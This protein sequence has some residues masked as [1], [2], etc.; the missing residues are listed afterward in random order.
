MVTEFK[1]SPRTLFEGIIYY[2][3]EMNNKPVAA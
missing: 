3:I 1:F 2:L